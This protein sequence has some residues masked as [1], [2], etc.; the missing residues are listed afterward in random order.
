MKENK[1]SVPVEIYGTKYKLLADSASSASYVTMVAA[2]VDEQMHKIAEQ[3]PQL[4]L[5]RLAVLAAINTADELLKTKEQFE[6]ANAVAIEKKNQ[7]I[8]EIRGKIDEIQGKYDEAKEQLNELNAKHADT[9]KELSALREQHEAKLRELNQL[10]AQHKAAVQER[11][12]LF[13]KHKRMEEELAAARRQNEKA[14]QDLKALR[15]EHEALKQ[16]LAAAKLQKA[17]A[18][19]AP[20]REGVRDSGEMSIYEQY[21]KLKQEYT[22]LQNEFNEWIELTEEELRN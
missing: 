2:H 20:G 22:K 3:H 11:D 19:A 8:D 1:T 12:E 16:Q 18:E 15:S 10:R 4:D 14:E 13:K 21:E 17:S 6:R 5:A 9:V 7:E